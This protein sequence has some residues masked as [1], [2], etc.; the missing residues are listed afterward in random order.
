M[1]LRPLDVVVLTHGM[2]CSNTADQIGSAPLTSI[3]GNAEPP[4][5]RS[6]FVMLRGA[7]RSRSIPAQRFSENPEPGSRDYARGDESCGVRDDE[8]PDRSPPSCRI[9]PWCC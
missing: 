6:P 2:T 3:N 5:R 4:P 7:K 8:L 9:S 1:R